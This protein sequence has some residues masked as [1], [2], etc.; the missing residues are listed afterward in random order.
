MYNRS[1]TIGS[2]P[3]PTGCIAPGGH[4]PAVAMGVSLYRAPN[5]QRSNEYAATWHGEPCFDFDDRETTRRPRQESVAPPTRSPPYQVY[6]F[7]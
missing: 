7:A 6:V 5:Q 4:S 3:A 2:I 1:I